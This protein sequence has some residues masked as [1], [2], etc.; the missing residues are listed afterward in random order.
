MKGSH[1]FLLFTFINKTLTF[2]LSPKSYADKKLTV[3][4]ILKDID[5]LTF[6]LSLESCV[7]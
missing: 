2:F 3:I 5:I 4:C 1:S 6:S 7:N